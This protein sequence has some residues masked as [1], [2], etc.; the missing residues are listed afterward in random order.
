MSFSAEME[1]LLSDSYQ[2]KAAGKHHGKQVGLFSSMYNTSFII[3][4]FEYVPNQT[5]LSVI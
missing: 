1:S 4:P 2:D 5:F 3:G